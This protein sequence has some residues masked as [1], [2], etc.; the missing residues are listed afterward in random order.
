MERFFS[1]LLLF[2]LTKAL[3]ADHNRVLGIAANGVHYHFAVEES[4][5]EDVS[6]KVQGWH[7]VDRATF[8]N[9]LDQ[10]PSSPL[11]SREGQTAS[12]IEELSSLGI[13][14]SV[15]SLNIET[16]CFA[17]PNG[18]TSFC[19]SNF[20]EKLALSPIQEVEL[21]HIDG[22][23]IC[24]GI[25]VEQAMEQALRAKATISL[26]LVNLPPIIEK[27]RE[28]LLGLITAYVNL[29]FV[30]KDE[31]CALTRLTPKD[32]AGFLKNFCDIVV[33]DEG[34]EGCWIG[35]KD[36]LFHCP[37][38]PEEDHFAVKGSFICGFLY[39]FLQ[40][41]SLNTC[42]QLGNLA[43]WQGS[44]TLSHLDSNAK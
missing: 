18:Q 27:L 33:V 6:L 23:V 22:N 2:V 40:H 36:K 12:L 37:S 13:A 19:I 9:I 28:R 7:E 42:A 39:G 29:L 1:L 34:S 4:F 44:R 10:I 38:T 32:A 21:V 16:A 8:D 35:S 15:D 25:A 43:K 41:R 17:T 26:D 30:N 31:A 5:L 14:S 20:D 11:I 3:H 24:N